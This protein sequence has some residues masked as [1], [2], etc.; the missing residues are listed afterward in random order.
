MLERE[1]ESYAGYLKHVFQSGPMLEDQS[2]MHSSRRSCAQRE[3]VMHDALS[4]FMPLFAQYESH[5]SYQGVESSKANRA[6]GENHLDLYQSFHIPSM[7][8]VRRKKALKFQERCQHNQRRR[9]ME[10]DVWVSELYAQHHDCIPDSASS[11]KDTNEQC[12]LVQNNLSRKM[13]SL[14]LYGLPKN[15]KD[16]Y[17]RQS[18]LKQIA[19]RADSVQRLAI[20]RDKIQ[21]RSRGYCFVTFVSRR[22]MIEAYRCLQGIMIGGK[23][24]GVD[25]C[26]GGL[27]QIN[28][29]NSNTF[30]K[31]AQR[32]QD[33][34]ERSMS[35]A[36]PLRKRKWPKSFL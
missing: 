30:L 3:L 23:I 20:V 36:H 18:I 19:L 29:I 22:D 12:V 9:R 26:R 25:V 35:I 15:L 33:D 10:A 31:V 11:T 7:H 17:I 24:I 6:Y 8:S 16:S 2:C 28:D 27:Q 14:I 34:K 13:R 5:I 32:L 21:E 4:K 1:C